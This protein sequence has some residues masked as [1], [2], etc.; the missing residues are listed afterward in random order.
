MT[1]FE[2][3]LQH[4]RVRSMS[5]GNIEPN[6]RVEASAVQRR[7]EESGSSDPITDDCLSTVKVIESDIRSAGPSRSNETF[8]L[9]S[10]RGDL[11]SCDLDRLGATGNTSLNTDIREVLED[12]SQVG[13][14]TYTQAQIICRFS[15]L[16]QFVR[17]TLDLDLGV[18]W[19]QRARVE[20]RD[21]DVLPED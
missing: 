3:F 8:L 7:G 11:D 4:K 20:I 5:S 14:E 6:I 17:S 19:R 10:T 12:R 15:R 13:F 18:G 9:E 2:P 16:L 21:K 1:L